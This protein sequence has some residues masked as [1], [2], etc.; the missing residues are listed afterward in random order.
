M[1]PKKKKKKQ[2][3]KNMQND[4][5]I[6]EM[7]GRTLT[8]RREKREKLFCMYGDNYRVGEGT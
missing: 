8:E 3:Q 5:G 1:F 4:R 7:G 6:T 2:K